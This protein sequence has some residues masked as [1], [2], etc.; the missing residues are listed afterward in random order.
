MIAP[1]WQGLRL[2]ALILLLWLLSLAA[3]LLVG[4]ARLGW[5]LAL[6]TVLVR[7]LLHTG[8]FIVAH[9]AMHGLLVPQ[10][11]RWNHRLGAFALALYA[12][13]AY[14][15]C[16]RNH[17]L[18]HQQTATASDP[19]F[20][21]DPEAGPLGWYLHFMG[22][23]L[24]PL[25]M[26][27]LLGGWG[28]LATG[29]AVLMQLPWQQALLRV[30]LGYTLPLLLSSLQLFVVGTYL[31]HR[32]SRVRS[33]DRHQAASLAWP[34]ALSLLACFHF[35]YHWEHHHNPS[36]PWYRLPDRRRWVTVPDGSGASLALGPVRR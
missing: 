3:V 31:P 29:G 34:P 32:R 35:G 21:G 7:T 10:R 13:L 24:N 30:L 17:G 5:P 4:P 14:D 25:Q 20:L 19:D 12:A 15:R 6:A 27:L 26:G 28:A 2:A 16:R 1:D 11:P 8:L 23:Y 9:D 22:G 33:R 18:H 36:L